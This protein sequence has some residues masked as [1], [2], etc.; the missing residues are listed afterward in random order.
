VNAADHPDRGGQFVGDVLTGFL[1][2]LQGTTSGNSDRSDIS[3]KVGAIG[4]PDGGVPGRGLEVAL[5]S[6]RAFS[7]LQTALFDDVLTKVMVGANKPL[8]GYI[9][10][11]VCPP[12]ATLMGMQQYSPQSVMIEVVGYRSPEA[13]VVMNRIQEK[14]LELN[15]KNRLQAL[16]HWGLEN[17]LLSAAD[18]AHTP[19][20]DMIPGNSTFTRLAAFR[21]VRQ[22]LRHGNPPV[23]DNNFVRRLQL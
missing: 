18:L 7:F 10:I 11:R 9:S 12:T 2:A 4:W 21:A 23:F 15:A 8:L 19:L 6:S 5:D 14:V 20:N 22:F 16:L 3:Y 13:N 1:N 17:H